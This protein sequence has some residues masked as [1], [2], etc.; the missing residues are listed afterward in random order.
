MTTEASA[1][2]ICDSVTEEGFRLVTF[3]A[4]GW[5]PILA[6]QN[7][8]CVLARNSASSRAIPVQKMLDRFIDERVYNP[9]VWPREQRGMQG[10]VDLTGGDLT[11]AILL[12]DDI[13]FEIGTRVQKYVDDHPDP[14]TRLHKS[15]LNRLL[16]NGLFQTQIITATQWDGYFWQRCHK[17]AEP[18]IRAMA[19]AMKDAMDA[20]TPKL[21][22]PGEWHLPYW[23][24]NGG[25]ETDWLYASHQITPD[26]SSVALPPDHPEVLEVAKRC[27]AARC[28]RVS[29]LTQ[30][31]R[32]DLNEDLRL[33]GDLTSNR[34]GSENPPHA[35]YD[36]ETEVLT[37]RGF[38]RFEALRA[39]DRLGAYDPEIGSLVY[40]NPEALH[41]FAYQ[42]EMYRVDHPKVDLLVTP[43]HRMWTSSRINHGSGGMEWS[44]PRFSE[45]KV[46]GD[47][48]MVRYF[49]VAP[50][51]VTADSEFPGLP[52]SADSDALFE[53]VGFF[54]GDGHAGR[55]EQQNGNRI[56]F[57]LKRPRKVEYLRGLATRLGWPL[58][59]QSHDTYAFAV[60][61]IGTAFR[62]AFYTPA[63]EKTLVGRF[64]SRQSGLILNG[65]RN[66]DGSNRRSTWGY[67]T[68]SEPLKN[69]VEI[70]L[71]HA[72]ESWSTI[73]SSSTNWRLSVHAEREPVVNQGRLSTSYEEYDGKVYCAS[74]STG[75]LVVRRNGQ[76]VVC[77]NS[78]LE[79]VATPWAENVQ[80]VTMPNGVTMGPLPRLGKLTGWLQLRHLELGF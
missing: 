5:R 11:D 31:G 30:D 79:H 75:L 35:C 63:G 22:K 67:D 68:N 80:N 3:E 78:P 53:L 50:D 58:L 64:N 66:S 71:L 74:V 72:G 28:A 55:S 34:I 65:L 61:G 7:T 27:S 73:T 49:K 6:E 39:E 23:S 44:A 26:F 4:A 19:M 12:W 42:G 76:V 16:E 37:D 54:L 1:R 36:A 25:H 2:V 21:L 38:V 69:A 57:H 43:N 33:Y 32:R 13:Q 52:G 48:T 56:R 20:S 15:I 59:E 40:E 10:G 29:Y 77:G 24:V 70:L 51:L 45:A 14:A 18:H 47:R 9:I 62:D 8:H 17:D 41:E 46:L 60:D